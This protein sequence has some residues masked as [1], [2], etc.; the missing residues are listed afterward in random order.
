MSNKNPLEVQIGGDHYKTMAIQPVEFSTVNK[1]GFLEGSVVKRMA[2]HNKPTGKGLEDID[3]AI[4]ELQLLRK[5]A[6]GAED[7]PDIIRQQ[8]AVATKPQA[9][10]ACK[11][12][13]PVPPNTP[14]WCT[15]TGGVS[16]DGVPRDSLA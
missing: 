16:P 15:P 6:Y 3:K 7:A 2:R 4:H 9:A 14:A 1:L 10:V 12:Q 8:P 13:V 11:P 5:L